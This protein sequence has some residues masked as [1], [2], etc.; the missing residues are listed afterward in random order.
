MSRIQADFVAVHDRNSAMLLVNKASRGVC[1]PA[2]GSCDEVAYL[3]KLQPTRLDGI[4]VTV[5]QYSHDHAA[6]L[7]DS[8]R[9]VGLVTCG[10]CLV[11]HL[12]STSEPR[13]RAP[14]AARDS[15]LNALQQP[16]PTLT[17]NQISLNS[18]KT[19]I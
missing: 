7:V 3:G 6:G 4:D 9:R 14:L 18:R 5:K 1:V 17:D 10:R 12:P 13:A 16:H 19:P 11:G 8:R 15:N 2:N